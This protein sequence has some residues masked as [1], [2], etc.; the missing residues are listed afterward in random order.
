MQTSPSQILA[1]S[2]VVHGQEC[3]SVLIFHTLYRLAI[4]NVMQ[5]H[6][7]RC[8]HAITGPR[9]VGAR[10]YMLYKQISKSRVNP[11]LVLTVHK[12]TT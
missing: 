7:L 1:I 8:M 10:T 2:V 6:S 9:F 3:I 5:V 4:V 12:L 11:W